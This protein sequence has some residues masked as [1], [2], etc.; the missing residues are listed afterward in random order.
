[1]AKKDPIRG[2]DPMS[3]YSSE[4]N[5]RAGSDKELLTAVGLPA[6]IVLGGG[7]LTARAIS[8]RNKERAENEAEAKKSGL[9]LEAENVKKDERLKKENDAYEQER[10]KGMK[11][12]GSVKSASA[13]ADGIAQRGKTRG[14]MY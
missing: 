9:A 12:G 3:D 2:I 7:L 14:K 11:K 5:P 13:R 4:I 10:A 8:K 6:G 1:M